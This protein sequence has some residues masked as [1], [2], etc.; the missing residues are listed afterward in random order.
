MRSILAALILALCSATR[1]F[2]GAEADIAACKSASERGDF[3]AAIERCTE[4][5]EGKSSRDVVV[6]VLDLRASAY[7]DKKQYEHAIEDYDQV[8]RLDPGYPLSYINRGIAHRAMGNLDAAIKDYDAA[9]EITPGIAVAY[10]NRGNAYRDKGEYDLAIKDY[11]LAIKL[12]P[13]DARLYN[14]RGGAH[15]GKNDAE[16]AIA[17]Y[18]R[19]IELDPSLAAAY[20]DRGDLQNKKGEFALGLQDGAS[21]IALD[22]DDPAGWWVKGAAEFG[23]ARHQAAATTLANFV[24][25]VPDDPYGILLL[26]MAQARAGQAGTDRLRAHAERLDLSRWPGPLARHLLGDLPKEEVIGAAGTN[27]DSHC[28]VA[29]YLGQDLLVA[30]E[31][32]AARIMLR[33]A[34]DICTPQLVERALARAELSR[35]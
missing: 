24:G 31:K 35:L 16:R 12:E 2:A 3:D 18:S 25:R 4:A 15:D 29:F 11:D 33:S 27:E 34:A 6:K 28:D 10:N 26:H 1:A 8:I 13:T 14:N 5:L 20:M 22:P 32:D 7:L 23:L 21:G 19:A 9:I 17:D 30:G